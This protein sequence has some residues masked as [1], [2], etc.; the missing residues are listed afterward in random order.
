MKKSTRSIILC[1]LLLAPMAAFAQPIL[2]IA[3]I[4]PFPAK[5]NASSTTTATFTV[6]NTSSRATVTPINQSNFPL[7]LTVASSTCGTP[8][9][10]GQSCTITLSLHPAN[11][12][13]IAT[14]LRIWAKPTATGVQYPIH[15]TVHSANYDVIVVG[16]GMSG[17]EA[18][19][20]L[21][22]NNL[23]VLIL[24]ARNRT[25]G[26][27][28]TTTMAGIPTDLGASWLHDT[29]NNVLVDL[30]N[31]LGVP[32]IPTPITDTQVGIYNNG[33]LIDPNDVDIIYA[34]APG[35]VASLLGQV[36]TSCGTYN[37]AVNCYV[38]ANIPNMP[39]LAQTYAN[40]VYNLEYSGW[41]GENTYHISSVV[42]P[43]LLNFGPISGN[44][45]DFPGNGYTSFINQ[46]FN[47]N[48]L[49]IQL[50]STVNTINYANNTVTVSTNNG[51]YNAKY[52]VVTVPLGV[53]KTNAI[54]FIPSLPQ[55]KQLAIQHIGYGS[56]N[57]IFLQFAYV[58][59]DPSLKAFLPYTADPTM[60]YY[61][62]LNYGSFFNN[63]PILLAFDVGD[64]SRMLEQQSDSY[65]IN[66][67]MTQIRLIYPSA[68]NPINYQI[69]RW[70]LDPLSNGAYSFPTPQ[71]TIDDYYNLTTPVQN[72]LFFAGEAVNAIEEGSIDNKSG[73]TDAAYI[74]GENAANSILN[75]Q[76]ARP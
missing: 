70:G 63:Q 71:T 2:S 33:T 3:A 67:I 27:L 52:V 31:N 49:N 14:E 6:T 57:K 20:V 45:D 26:R 22:Q 1:L 23:D 5:V 43:S 19:T 7:G 64:F 75:V 48:V 41:F 38:N 17:L 34:Y 15:V 47:M 62:I 50:N 55:D 30:A 56:F 60:N 40:Y 58:F 72:K 4:T 39:P 53:L 32:L 65:I 74:S 73:T 42:G 68:P 37:D 8:L 76:F 69:T 25:G 46:I 29:D 54:Q 36:Y 51:T 28:V 16:A 18:A 9:T 10:P 44:P 35:L 24:E 11:A 66:N 12:Q 59:W 13:T 21:Q 61:T